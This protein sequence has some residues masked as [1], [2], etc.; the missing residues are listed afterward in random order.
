MNITKG[1]YCQFSL[2]SRLQLAKEFGTCLKE[3]WF[4]SLFIQIYRMN[5]F[6][7]E[8]HY[9][10]PLLKPVYAEPLKNDG[11]LSFYQNQPSS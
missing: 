4:D 6:Y 5:D 10:A 3:I 9:Q 2:V 1:E 11:M 7:V 8:I